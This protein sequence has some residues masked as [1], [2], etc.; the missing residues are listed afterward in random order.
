MLWR[1][2]HQ[3]RHTSNVAYGAFGRITC[4]P[5]GANSLE[6][7]LIPKARPD[8][9]G[10]VPPN[11]PWTI[12]PIGVYKAVVSTTV[13]QKDCDPPRSDIERSLGRVL[14]GASFRSSAQ[15]Q[16][17]LRYIVEHSLAH[18][19]DMLR[20]RMIG[21]NVFRRPSDYDSGNDPIV[22]ARAA[23]VR[24]RL[25]QYY[26][27]GEGTSE[28]IRIEIPSGSYKAVFAMRNAGEST[29]LHRGTSFGEESAFSADVVGESRVSPKVSTDANIHAPTIKAGRAMP[30]WRPWNHSGRGPF[31]VAVTVIGL[32]IGVLGFFLGHLSSSQTFKHQDVSELEKPTPPFS[33]DPVASFWAPFLKEDHSPII[34]YADA[35]FLID[36]PGD[37]F[38]FRHGAL[39][40]RGAFVDAHLARQFAS[41]P[42]L[43]AS[44]GTLFY[45][46]GYTGTGD[47]RA[48]A[49]LVAQLAHM[50]ATPLVKSSYDIS[51]D[52]LKQHNVILLGSPSE[53]LAVAQIVP[54]GD[55]L[56]EGPKSN[57]DPWSDEIINSQPRAGE[58]AK[59]ETK[60]DPGSHVLQGDFALVTFQPGITPDHQIVILG[61]IDTTGTEGAAL[62]VT[63][64]AGVEELT[65]ALA[66]VNTT[67]HSGK[68]RA[69]QALVGVD[70]KK[71]YQVLGARLVTLHPLSEAKSPGTS[72]SSSR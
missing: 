52:D 48:M 35:M 16:A 47:L 60:R 56:F 69:F 42:S 36:G 49:M 28:D 45:D 25:A 62:L 38:R 46:N 24:K 1:I 68:G 70:V 15:C 22:R 51:I 14:T 53:D 5:M 44:A 4:I 23:E 58:Q 7:W 31:L 6:P 40:N 32:I 3:L 61:G 54:P 9:G 34:A 29:D 27:Q 71:G 37:L 67:P 13:Q 11:E 55:F 19:E 10:T 66:Q 64:K 18:E 72:V 21:I 50:G 41:N 43:V 59:Y 63:S 33:D 26:L 65:N 20:E 8:T 2:K 30:G 12:A 39:D 57:R 17:L